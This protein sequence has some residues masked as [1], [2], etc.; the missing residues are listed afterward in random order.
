MKIF[1][2]SYLEDVSEAAS[3]VGGSSLKIS[4][5]N[6]K[7]HIQS[8]GFKVVKKE[9]KSKR[10]NSISIKATSSGNAKVSVTSF[11]SNTKEKELENELADLEKSFEDW[12]E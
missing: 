10:G 7:T 1:D 8:S 2:L 9:T 4:T 3:I 6:G 12:D 11:T 5:K